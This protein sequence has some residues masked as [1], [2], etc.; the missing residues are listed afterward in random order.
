MWRTSP[1]DIE[2]VA[3]F[4]DRLAQYDIEPVF[5]HTSYL[6]NLGSHDEELYG[7]SVD[8]L[9]VELSRAL[10]AGIP[11]VVTH[12]GTDPTGDADRAARRIAEACTR[13]MDAAASGS[14]VTLLLENSSGSG[15]HFGGSMG[16]LGLLVALVRARDVGPV[17]ACLDTCHAHAYGADVSTPEGWG[18]L[19]DALDAECGAGSV[20]LLHAND[21]MFERGSKRDR[22]A[23]V[24]EGEIGAD[25][26]C[27]MFA[28]PRLEG[29]PIVVE[30][31]GE[32]PEKDRLN[33]ERLKE[34]RAAVADR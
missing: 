12:V 11:F 23:W 21:A 9:R 28:E 25:G 6:I 19:L 18:V 29:V 31:P 5:A 4:H 10:Q 8:G 3:E 30:M 2:A 1:L 27:A 13:A 17:A 7:R 14:S 15:R 26:F 33:I 22:H 16:E 20:G 24:G 32:M 34:M